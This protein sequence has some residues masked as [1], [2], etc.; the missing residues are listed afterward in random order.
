M[1][2]PNCI[3]PTC[4]REQAPS[5]ARPVAPSTPRCDHPVRSGSEHGPG[6]LRTSRL[7]SISILRL[8]GKLSDTHAVVGWRLVTE[9]LAT[10]GRVLERAGQH[11]RLP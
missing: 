5:P 8:W 1:R 11:Q 3:V 7:Y 9:D 6:W 10:H 2:L 4:F